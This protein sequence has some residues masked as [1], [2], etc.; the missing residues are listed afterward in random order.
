MKSVAEGG[1][2]EF[3]LLLKD[4]A[5]PDDGLVFQDIRLRVAF[6][7]AGQSPWAARPAVSITS[8]AT[9][10]VPAQNMSSCTRIRVY[11]WRL[12]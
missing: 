3:L 5:L 9:P 12:S 8:L 7:V 4:K 6:S 1:N 11:V 10:M 2:L